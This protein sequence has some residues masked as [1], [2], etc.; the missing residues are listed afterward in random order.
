MGRFSNISPAAMYVEMGRNLREGLGGIG[1]NQLA[2]RQLDLQE[3]QMGYNQAVQDRDWNDPTRKV[4]RF[5]SQ[6][7]LDYANAPAR[8]TDLLPQGDALNFLDGAADLVQ[9]D[10]YNAVMNVFSAN[11]YS[12]DNG[13]ILDKDRRPVTRGQLSSLYP[14]IQEGIALAI[15]PAHWD[16]KRIAELRDQFQKG[17]IT[18]K[19]AETL[20]ILEERRDDP[21]TQIR[22]LSFLADRASNVSP[23]SPNYQFAQQRAADLRNRIS[24]IYSRMDTDAERKLQRAALAETSRANV[25]RERLARE[26]LGAKQQAAAAAAQKARIDAL[27]DLYKNQGFRITG[28]PLGGYSILN[29]RTGATT[30]VD[31]DGNVLRVQPADTTALEI[32]QAIQRSLGIPVNEA[33]NPPESGAVGARFIPQAAGGGSAGS[34]Q[35]SVTPTQADAIRNILSR[36]SDAQV[37]LA[38][39]AQQQATASP[40]GS[41]PATTTQP[42]PTS[43]G[44]GTE[45]TPESR[46]RFGFTE[47]DTRKY[48]P[49]EGTIPPIAEQYL[50]DILQKRGEAAINTTQDARQWM[51]EAW[52]DFLAWARK[53]PVERGIEDE[54]VAKVAERFVA[55]ARERGVPDK[56]I[57]EVVRRP[58]QQPGLFSTPT[59]RFQ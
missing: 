59:K 34:I 31:S 25:A 2:N 38:P 10:A 50:L 54:Q 22:V 17:G 43:I 46:D 15:N 14:Q 30:Q 39:G 24:S 21:E 33:P 26:E 12:V 20:K 49:E 45:S 55:A 48:N 44:D 8:I 23:N 9:D 27:M 58:E 40:Q 13:A 35:P 11:G 52:N 41:Q 57:E 42:P 28:D 7:K 18:D 56:I 16:A 1:R 4:Q 53:S 6:Q 51:S 5:E 3:A 47:N 36:P 32:S 19:E 37:P 29:Q